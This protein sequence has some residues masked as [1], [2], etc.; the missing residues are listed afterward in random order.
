MTKSQCQGWARLLILVTFLYTN[1]LSLGCFAAACCGGASALPGLITGDYKYE[2]STSFHMTAVLGTVVNTTNEVRTYWVEDPWQHPTQSLNL[3]GAYLFLSYWQ[4]NLALPLMP[5]ADRQMQLGDMTTALAYEFMP[6]REYGQWQPRGIAFF[7]LGWP[8]GPSLFKGDLNASSTSGL[9]TF[10][11]AGG[12][13]LQKIWGPYDASLSGQWQQPLPLSGEEGTSQNFMPQ[14]S[15]HIAAGY[16]PPWA[17]PLRLGARVGRVSQP[18]G[19]TPLGE[20][21]PERGVS[22]LAL[23]TSYMMDE[24]T[25][26][27]FTFSDQSLLDSARNT[28]LERTISLL[29]Q[30][31]YF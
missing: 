11:P 22:D 10:V 15:L 31:G 12:I 26:F 20:P 6:E 18:H 28:N 17:P 9:G 19:T 1:S 16:S 8:T 3:A 23:T 24:S 2:F 7:S 4:V 27:T 13:W 21:I 30:K 5:T 25:S 29:M 14:L